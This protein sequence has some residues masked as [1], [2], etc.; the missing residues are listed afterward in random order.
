MNRQDPFELFT[1]TLARRLRERRLYRMR[2]VTKQVDVLEQLCGGASVEAFQEVLEPLEPDT[3][4][5][6]ASS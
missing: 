5:H 3:L 1:R 4:E 2:P 6:G